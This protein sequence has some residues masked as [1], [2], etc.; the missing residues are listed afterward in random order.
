MKR[1][2]TTED[3]RLLKYEKRNGY[4]F[5]GMIL[6]AGVLFNLI[7][8]AM[9]E[10]VHPQSMLVAVDAGIIGL[11]WLTLFYTNRN[12]NN[13]LQFGRRTIKTAKITR[14]EKQKTYE[15]G[16]GS[17]SVPIL[18]NLFPKIWGQEMKSRYRFN[19]IINQARY[20]V[21]KDLYDKANE[22]D[23]VEMYYAEYSKR[24]L[25]ISLAK[26]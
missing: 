18:G 12:L 6:M 22:G 3:I 20:E 21:E 10:I 13:D 17:L 16:S 26:Q 5:A 14:K 1:R 9:T 23:E 24:L 2:L 8:L 4:V 25:E 19:L 11:S 7:D 15:A